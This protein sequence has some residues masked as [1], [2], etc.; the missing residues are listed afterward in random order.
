MD[1]QLH[2]VEKGSGPP[3]LLLHGNGENS[4]Y[5]CRQIDY[6]Q[7]AFHVY[8]P[9]TRGHGKSPRGTAPFTLEQFALDLK[10]FMD[11]K[12]I[13]K[14]DI[15]GFSDGANIALLFALKNPGR[16]RRLIL[17]GADLFPKGVK[18]S[19]Q[20]PII[21]GYGIVSFLSLFSKKAI[22]KKEMLGLMVTQPCIAP[23]E[24]ASLNMPVLVIAGTKDMIRL[25]HT[26][27]IA[28][29]IPGSKLAIL[30]G[31][32]FIASKKWEAFNRSVDAFF[33]ERK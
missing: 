24:L 17:N 25:S 15:L 23:G 28:R 11:E 14:A 13:G 4:D 7:E 9:D 3:L 31:D 1:I 32:H 22:P 27:L 21:I 30:E 18:R 12:G 8:A 16:V 26:Q 29:S 2:Y 19:V 33:T 10:D 6:F 5:F 20:I